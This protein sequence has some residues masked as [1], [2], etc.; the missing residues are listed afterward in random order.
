MCILF[1]ACIYIIN[2]TNDNVAN[3]VELHRDLADK[4]STINIETDDAISQQT[5]MITDIYASEIKEAKDIAR[6]AM[7]DEYLNFISIGGINMNVV[8][9]GNTLDYREIE[10]N[11]QTK[12]ITTYQ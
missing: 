6:S 8:R 5:D 2:G 1:C 3:L 9:L 12:V 7:Y 4:V 10:V 11:I